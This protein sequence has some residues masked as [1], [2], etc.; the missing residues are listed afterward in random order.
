[1]RRSWTVLGALVTAVV[2]GALF[3]WLTALA[4]GGEA[5]RIDLPVERWVL[6]HRAG[7][8]TSVLRVLTSMGSSVVLWVIV[9]VGAVLFWLRGRDWPSAVILV[10]AL[11]GALVAKDVV[12]ALVSRPRPAATAWLTNASG[13]AYPSGHAVQALVVSGAFALVLSP[14]SSR[15][16]RA[17]LWVGAL[18]VALIVGWSRVYLGVHWL[19]D[20]LGGYAL[21]G[22]WLAVLGALW[23]TV[24]PPAGRVRT[25]RYPPGP[26]P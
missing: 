25:E 22:T 7:W 16:R 9:G 17:A 10:A 21:A 15:R 18:L 6:D 8:A 24:R 1:M 26:G 11:V 4:V 23:L 2:L 12:K 14:G 20:V 3:G 13:L 19:T 5:D